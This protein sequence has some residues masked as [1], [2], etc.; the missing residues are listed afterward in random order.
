MVFDSQWFEQNQ[1]K[2]L[3]LLNTPIIKYWFRWCLRIRRHDCTSRIIK[4]EPNKYW[5][6]DEN[7]YVDIRTHNKFSKRLYYAFK[8]F[9]YLL[10]GVDFLL[11]RAK[12]QYNFGFDTLTA[13]PD[14]SSGGTTVDGVVGR[15]E[16]DETFATIRAGAGNGFDVTG[17][18]D[19]FC[20]LDATTTTDQFAN[21]IRGIYTFDTSNLRWSEV[22][23]VTLS[24]FGQGTHYV[25]LSATGGTAADIHVVS[26]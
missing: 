26:A 14:A 1:K 19:Y 13:Y 17:T 22:S 12:F 6:Q 23:S 5:F 15:V 21:L 20:G 2:L 24:L 9:W 10:H 18:E 7:I 4:I 16:V 25:G 11:N 3:W 8:P